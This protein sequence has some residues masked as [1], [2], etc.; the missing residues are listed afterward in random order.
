M[1][2]Y[3]LHEYGGKYEDS[4]DHIIGSYLR[5]ERAEE[6]KADAE[7]Q[8]RELINRSEKCMNCPFLEKPFNIFE[9]LMSE[10]TDYCNNQGLHDDDEYGMYCDNYY[11]HYCTSTFEIKEVEVEE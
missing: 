3:Q 9:A 6:E 8:E 7:Y 4:F 2:I 5:K 10:Y 11:S 1:K